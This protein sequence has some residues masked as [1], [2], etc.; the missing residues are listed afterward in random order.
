LHDLLVACVLQFL[1]AHLPELLGVLAAA[2]GA[3]DRL[4][5]PALRQLAPLLCGQVRWTRYIVITRRFT[6]RFRDVVVFISMIR[7]LDK[8]DGNVG[9]TQSVMILE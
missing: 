9:E 5:P 8:M 3:G 6:L 7:T 1:R 4:T 2:T